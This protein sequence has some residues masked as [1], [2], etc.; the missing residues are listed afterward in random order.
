M[1]AHEWTHIKN[2]DLW[3]LALDRVILTLLWAHPLYWWARRRI[4]TN[5]ELLADAAA[6]S[7]IGPA[8]Y[9]ALLVE[10]ARKLA[11]HRG[12]TAF[13][14]V[15]IWERPAALEQRVTEILNHNHAAER[16]SDR[17]RSTPRVPGGLGSPRDVALAATYAGEVCIAVHA[18][19]SDE[20]SES[21]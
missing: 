11:T 12:L 3:L 19:G 20:V 6:A 14:A 21:A 15:G 7:Q 8:D 9:A 17:V 4:R 1:L 5:Q 13:T 16:C 18:V 10:W 2:G